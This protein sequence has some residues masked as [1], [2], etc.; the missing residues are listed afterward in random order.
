MLMQITSLMPSI[1][2]KIRS[3]L[4]PYFIS[5]TLHREAMQAVARHVSGVV[6]DVGCGQ[7]PYQ[8][9]FTKAIKYYGIEL[10]SYRG[11]HE[12]IDWYADG[13]HLPFRAK[14]YDSIII[15][16]VLEHVPEPIAFLDELIRTLKPGG[17]IVISTPQT[18][19]IHEAPHDYYRYTPYGLAYLCHKA[20]LTTDM[21]VKTNGSFATLTQRAIPFW[22]YL[23]PIRKNTI[24]ECLILAT[25]FLP[26][27]MA[28]PI[29][30]LLKKRGDTLFNIIVAK[31]PGKK[32]ISN[33]RTSPPS[34]VCPDCKKLLT[35][36]NNHL[37]CG[38]C[39][40]YFDTFNGKWNF[41]DR[42]VQ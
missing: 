35:Q 3:L 15:H 39:R 9:F 28:L 14:T 32:T 2:Y 5:S 4:D 37:E 23:F 10:P 12:Y 19:G 34:F 41:T 27:R 30:R 31:K 26:S 40:S 25:V 11:T 17:H 21:E 6:L 1:K 42:M 24:L 8:K 7:K 16:E 29:D 38:I 36:K 18:W 33:T 22:I 20:G 13:F